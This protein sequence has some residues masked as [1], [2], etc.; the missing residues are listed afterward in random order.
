[1]TMAR[2]ITLCIAVFALALL[3]GCGESAV[4]AT[5]D[6]AGGRAVE[7]VPHD[8]GLR[9]DDGRK[10]MVSP[11]MMVPIRRM[12][13]RLVAVDAVFLDIPDA[14][15]VLAESLFTDMDELVRTC[16]MKG[17]AHDMLHEW[18]MPHMT[19]LQRMEVSPNVDS[20][21]AVLE[22][23]QHSNTQFDEYFE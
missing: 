22:A 12:R 17:P 19:L 14:P 18:L 15:R 11:H 8:G 4:P 23:L 16:D 20:A 21:R 13:E 6:A 10:W 2:P 5:E 9:L 1:M 3:A 7:D